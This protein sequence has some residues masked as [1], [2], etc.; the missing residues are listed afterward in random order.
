M[1][2]E[3]LLQV[4]APPLSQCFDC[5]S[6]MKRASAFVEVSIESSEFRAFDRALNE[7]ASYFCLE[8]AEEIL[9]KK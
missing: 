7:E 2:F 5:Q 9:L 8:T 4:W 3:K 6:R 1:I